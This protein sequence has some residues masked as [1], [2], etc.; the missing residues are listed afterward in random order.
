MIQ[1]DAFATLSELLRK[2]ETSQLTCGRLEAVSESRRQ[3]K[4]SEL[5]VT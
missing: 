3:T 5:L 4:L 1:C 2:G